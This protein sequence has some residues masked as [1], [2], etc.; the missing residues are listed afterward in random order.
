MS[1]DKADER[2]N[3]RAAGDCPLDIHHVY[4][5]SAE[6]PIEGF[7]V[8]EKQAVL[9]WLTARLSHHSPALSDDQRAACFSDMYELP[10]GP[11]PEHVEVDK[12]AKVPQIQSMDNYIKRHYAQELIAGMIE[13]VKRRTDTIGKITEAYEDTFHI[14]RISFWRRSRTELIALLKM[15]LDAYNNESDTIDRYEYAAEIYFDFT[16]EIEYKEIVYRP[17]DKRTEDSVEEAF[18][19]TMWLLDSYLVPYATNDTI[20]KRAWEMHCRF[21]TQECQED[22]PIPVKGREKATIDNTLTDQDIMRLK[23]E[24]KAAIKHEYGGYELAKRMGLGII[25][26]ALYKKSRRKSFFNFHESQELVLPEGNDDENRKPVL[27]TIPSDTIVINTRRQEPDEGEMSVFHECIHWYW[28][29]LFYRLQALHN[30]DISGLQDCQET[31]HN[32]DGVKQSLSCMEYQANRGKYALKMPMPV[33]RPLVAALVKE[34]SPGSQHEG[35]VLDRVARHI[36][37]DRGIRP[38]LMRARMIQIGR[39]GAKG[40]LNYED[41]R[42]ISPF[43]FDHQNGA[44]DRVFFIR[45]KEALEEFITNPEFR[46]QLQSGNYVYAEGHVCIN[47][48]RYVTRTCLGLRLTSWANAHIDACCLRFV[49]VYT[50]TDLIEYEFGRLASDEEYNGHYVNYVR[51]D[52]EKMTRAEQIQANHQYVLALPGNFFEMLDVIRKD[53]GLSQDELEEKSGVPKKKLSRE[54]ERQKKKMKLNLT[55]DE[56]IAICIGLEAPPWLSKA[57]LARANTALN[58]LDPL[59][60]VYD[61]ILSCMFMDPIHTVQSFL[62]EN[63]CPELELK[64]TE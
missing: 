52:G 39:I 16:D 62:K 21:F 54:R 9:P 55:L 18:G 44:G 22:T 43:S 20:E 47:D 33:M 5:K 34:C 26:V 53:K 63:G 2:Q 8:L 14:D 10:E 13:D 64:R 50:L 4:V 40:I 23:E 12:S 1:R 59:H 38:Y 11:V 15:R 49:S 58:P 6:Q 42:Y 30:S 57:I 28:H 35:L 56:S 25:R 60:Q 19:E 51:A 29:Y 17:Y 24:R 31:T 7:L 37:D 36:I 61:Y 45:R 48:P 27:I 41:G 32:K 46:K 3:L